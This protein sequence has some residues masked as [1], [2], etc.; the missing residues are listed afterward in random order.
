MTNTDARIIGKFL[1][2]F[3]QT[4]SKIE[5]NAAVDFRLYATFRLSC[6]VQ[7]HCNKNAL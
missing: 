5:K 6:V 3:M 4:S 1:T 2:L 7:V